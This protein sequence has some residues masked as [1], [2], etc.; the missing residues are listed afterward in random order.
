MLNYQRV[1]I[2]HLV[3][4]FT[5]CELE[6][7]TML[8]IGKPSI[9]MGIPSGKIHH[10]IKNGKPSRMQLGPSIYTMANC[11]CHNQAGY[12]MNSPDKPTSVKISA[13]LVP[14]KAIFFGDIP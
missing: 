8:S 10:A 7:S 6:R 1:V 9:S 13:L 11:E 2:S 5:V 4:T 3:M 12:P 14:Y